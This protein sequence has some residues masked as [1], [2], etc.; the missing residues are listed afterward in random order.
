MERLIGKV[1]RVSGPVIRATGVTDATMMELVYTGE[2]RLIGEI[3]KLDHDEAVIQVYENTIGVAPG[4][5]IYGSG[6]PLSLELGPG[7]IGSIYDGIQRPLNK[8]KEI[9]GN[10]IGRG[11]QVNAI[12]QQK[13]WTFTPTVKQGDLVHGGMVIGTVQETQHIEHRIMIPLDI[14]SGNLQNIAQKGDYTVQDVIATVKTANGKT[15]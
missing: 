13:K 8:L 9:S 14:T 4:D 2:H 15:P 3:V 10:F 7:L 5:S 1:K 6:M 12:D 11:I